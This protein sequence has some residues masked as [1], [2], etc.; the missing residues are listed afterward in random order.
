MT[1]T[2]LSILRRVPAVLPGGFL[3]LSSDGTRSSGNKCVGQCF[4]LW[5]SPPL[6][7]MEI[8][9]P[10]CLATRLFEELKMN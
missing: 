9:M 2:G 6:L 10:V 4:K 7:K 1:S 3:S 8:L 5:L